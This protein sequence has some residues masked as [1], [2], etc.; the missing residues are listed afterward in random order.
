M[1]NRPII[2]AFA[3]VAIGAA[4]GALSTA[5]W[6][7]T[8]SARWAWLPGTLWGVLVGTYGSI[9]WRLAR[10]G[11]GRSWV[12]TLGMLLVG[13]SAGMLVGGLAL[14]AMHRPWHIWYTWLLPGVLGCTLVPYRLSG[15]RRDY[16]AAE[17]RRISA[18]D[19]VST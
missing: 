7:W 17:M 1:S 19:I 5:D 3:A 9:A 16:E 12:M 6:H 11:R 13:A 14:L 2:I 4:Y 15:V 18:S 8:V 10:I